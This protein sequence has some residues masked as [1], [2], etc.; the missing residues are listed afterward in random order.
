[1]AKQI[2]ILD[3]STPW[4][5]QGS[6]RYAMWATVPTN[7]T[8]MYVK[9]STYESVY[10]DATTTEVNSL[11]LGQV[12]E[13][14]ETYNFSSAETVNQIKAT[15][16]AKFNEYQNKITTANTW[17][18]YGTFYDGTSWVNGGL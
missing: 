1:M 10:V 3:R 15:L 18:S 5:G 13:T 4:S 14:V 9:D 7:H 17:Q 2:I 12:V 16:Q 8:V 6:F 11:R